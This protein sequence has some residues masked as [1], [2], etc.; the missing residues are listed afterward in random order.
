MATDTMPPRGVRGGGT[1]PRGGPGGWVPPKGGPGGWVPPG[2]GETAG[3]SRGSPPRANTD[4]AGYG[5]APHPADHGPHG[6]TAD[7]LAADAVHPASRRAARRRPGLFAG[8]QHHACPG[9]LPDHEPAGAERQ[10]GPPAADP[11]ERGRAGGQASR[12][13]AEP[14]PELHSRENREDRRRQAVQPRGQDQRSRVHSVTP[15]DPTRRPQTNRR[16]DR[17]PPGPP[18]RRNPSRPDLRRRPGPQ[19]S[20][21]G[22]PGP[23]RSAIMTSERPPAG[24]ADISGLRPPPRSR[25]PPRAR[26]Q[27]ARGDPA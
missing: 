21:T 3:G 7:P 10:P 11:H 24:P 15:Q 20:Q 14:P 18:S 25:R 2:E 26:R 17:R 13:A 12:H 1:P 9:G 4:A 6:E 16:D 8:D 5:P 23:A 27:A 19:V 22:A